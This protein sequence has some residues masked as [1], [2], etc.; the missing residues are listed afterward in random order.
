MAKLF[1]TP[2]FACST[3]FK[4]TIG[5][6][7]EIMRSFVCLPP[8]FSIQTH[9]F[10]LHYPVMKANT[11]WAA[12]KEISPCLNLTRKLSPSSL[13]MQTTHQE[14]FLFKHPSLLSLH[15]LYHNYTQIRSTSDHHT[16]NHYYRSV[17]AFDHNTT[18]DVAKSLWRA[19]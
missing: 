1:C 12:N 14:V 17:F 13:S 8:S 18:S 4:E 7:H 2:H 9:C 6:V 11:H 15:P 3:N 16:I 5:F 19:I 10:Q